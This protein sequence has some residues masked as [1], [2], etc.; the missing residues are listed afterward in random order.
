MVVIL[1]LVVDVAILVAS[2]DQL[3]CQRLF[4]DG[5]R[6]GDE[7]L[8][9]FAGAVA[10]GALPQGAIVYL[11]RNNATEAGKQA[12]RDATNACGLTVYV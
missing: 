12:V 1:L 3:L 6:I 9:A 10:N 4:L 5:N 7:G 11:P 2:L 8:S